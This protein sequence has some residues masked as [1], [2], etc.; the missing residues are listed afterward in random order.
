MTSVDDITG[1]LVRALGTRRV[2]AVY[3]FGSAAAGRMHPG[4]DI[5]LAVLFEEVPGA[6]E[7]LDLRMELSDIAGRGVDLAV[8]NTASPILA[9]QVLKHGRRLIV[10][11]RVAEAEFVIKTISM[12]YDLKRVRRPIEKNILR[13]AIYG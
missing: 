3:L 11:D 7:L 12:Y 4:S 13:G 1:G 6:L 8:L 9:M 10:R 5:D 2:C